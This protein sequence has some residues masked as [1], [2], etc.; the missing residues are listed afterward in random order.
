LGWVLSE[1]PRHSHVGGQLRMPLYVMSGWWRS[2][3]ELLSVVSR[4]LA[5]LALFRLVRFVLDASIQ[6]SSKTISQK[7]HRKERQ[8]STIVESK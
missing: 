4:A 6:P 7:R 2:S 5:G 8:R 3:I 1:P